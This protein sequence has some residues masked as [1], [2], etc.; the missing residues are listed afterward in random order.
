MQTDYL[1]I[2]QFHFSPAKEVL[3]HE[4]A[5]ETLY[6]LQRAGKI[7]FLGCSSILPHLTEHI[8]MGVFDVL[9]IPYSALQ[10][11]HEAAI[12]EAA[13]AGAGI[14]IR[15]GVA[16]GEPGAGQGSAD[17]W[18]LWEHA[19]MD[20]LLQGMSATEFML[21]FTITNSDIHTAIVGTLNPAH[22]HENIAAVL[23]GPLPASVYNEAK[24]R[25][26]VVRATPA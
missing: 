9:Q 5:I 15:G 12:A 11:E 13:R 17:V 4:G 18:K 25:L 1:D 10:P 16:R 7:R 19:Q 20:E 23:Q 3:V 14:V 24:R 2:L 6:D 8:A 21:R 22:L 26:A